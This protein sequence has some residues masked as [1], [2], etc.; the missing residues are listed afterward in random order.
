LR[1]EFSL[2]SHLLP[3]SLSPAL[4][5]VPSIIFLLLLFLFVFLLRFFLHFL[6]LPLLCF[7]D[8]F[9][10]PPSLILGGSHPPHRLVT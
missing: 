8:Y 2:A 3:F 6:S 4:A 1:L 7:S 10:L 5:A 9:P